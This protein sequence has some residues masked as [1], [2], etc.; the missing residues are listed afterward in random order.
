LVEAI[1]GEVPECVFVEDAGGSGEGGVALGEQLPGGLGSFQMSGGLGGEGGIS[2]AGAGPLKVAHEAGE[3][4][5]HGA[6]EGFKGNDGAGKIAGE[7]LI[8]QID[9]GEFPDVAD[10]IDELERGSFFVEGLGD[11]S[12][13]DNAQCGGPDGAAVEEVIADP[14]RNGLLGQHAGIE[15]FADGLGREHQ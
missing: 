10:A 11:F 12:Q 14:R 7:A 4:I 1:V 15:Q 5:G 3:E 8:G 2:A 6:S 13:L 9:Q